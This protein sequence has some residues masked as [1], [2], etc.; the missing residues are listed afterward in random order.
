[1]EDKEQGSSNLLRQK[2]K[3]TNQLFISKRHQRKIHHCK[4]PN[5]RH[6]N[7]KMKEKSINRCVIVDSHLFNFKK[8]HEKKNWLLNPHHTTIKPTQFNIVDV[9]ETLHSIIVEANYFESCTEYCMN[10]PFL[11]MIEKKFK[12]KIHHTPQSFKRANGSCR[13]RRDNAV[14]KTGFRGW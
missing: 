2:K 8:H 5:Y 13:K 11:K 14:V 12:R 1:M 7:L 3:K 9:I 4:S 10:K 6:G